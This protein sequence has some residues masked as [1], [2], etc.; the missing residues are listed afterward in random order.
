MDRR[1]I[2][3]L[4]E[5][6]RSCRARI[7]IGL[8]NPGRDVL[9][10]LVPAGEYAEIIAVGDAAPEGIELI[11][12]ASPE[13][14]LIRL[15]MSSEIDGAVRG[16]ISATRTMRALSRAGIDV[17]RMALLELGGWAFFLAPVGIDEGETLQDKLELGMRGA[18]FLR[19]MGVDP[20]VSV[21][22]GGRLEDVGR[23]EHVDTSLA[24]GE[25]VAA[26]LRE[27]GFDAIHR[28]IL[29]ESARGDDLVLAPDGISG[30][31]LFRTMLMVCGATAM[32]APVLTDEIVFVDST[33]ARSEFIGP[34]I[35]ASALVSMRCGR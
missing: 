21:L 16:N 7:G 28:G 34:I 14:E 24:H 15:L 30:N 33:R 8:V 5:K 11:R 2:D 17:M 23:S 25:F 29:I 3:L 35:L 6:A 13:E 26:R 31:L 18:S 12:S 4:E 19:G 20:T 9:E 1:F 10:S 32:G 27:N 22:S